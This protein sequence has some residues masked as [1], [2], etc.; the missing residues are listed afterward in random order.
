MKIELKSLTDIDPCELANAANDPN[1][2]RYL[3]KSF[4]YPYT[5]D[6][7]M[8]FITHSL[9]HQAVDFGIVINNVCV[10]CVGVT[11]HQ[12]IY[13]KNCDIGYWLNSQYWGLGIMT[14]VVHIL[15]DYLFYHFSIHKICAEVYA[16]NT[17][18]SY[19]LKKNHFM[20]EGYLK[21]HVYKDGLYHDLI[22][23]S[24][25]ESEYEY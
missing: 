17:A 2:S 20:E 6:H 3:K 5:L 25:R 13:M 24:L 16:E 7:A 14:K 19:V 8:S 4:P 15:C 10:G 12:D 22:L 11:F 9:E 18:S 21:E 23:Y 1:V